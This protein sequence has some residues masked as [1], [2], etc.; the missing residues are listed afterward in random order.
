ML[1]IKLALESQKVACNLL[2]KSN[3]INYLSKQKQEHSAQN[4][5]NIQSLIT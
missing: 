4:L 1:K 5:N 2:P 3:Q